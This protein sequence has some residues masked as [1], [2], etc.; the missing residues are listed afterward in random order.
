MPHHLHIIGS[1]VLPGIMGDPILEDMP[2]YYPNGIRDNYFLDASNIV[3]IKRHQDLTKLFLTTMAKMHETQSTREGQNI[4]LLQMQWTSHFEHAMHVLQQP[5]LL[6]EYRQESEKRFQELYTAQCNAEEVVGFNTAL[7]PGDIAVCQAKRNGDIFTVKEMASKLPNTDSAVL[8]KVLQHDAKNAKIVFEILTPYTWLPT[9]RPTGFQASLQK[10]YPFLI[11]L[12]EKKR[13]QTSFWVY[14]LFGPKMGAGHVVQV[15][16]HQQ[17]PWFNGLE[18]IILSFDFN[19]AAWLVAVTSNMG[20]ACQ[21]V[22]IMLEPCFSDAQLRYGKDLFAQVQELHNHRQVLLENNTRL[23]ELIHT[24]AH[25][26]QQAAGQKNQ[27]KE[28]GD[29]GRTINL[30]YLCA[31]VQ[32]DVVMADGIEDVEREKVDTALEMPLE[33]CHASASLPLMCDQKEPTPLTST[34]AEN[35]EAAASERQRLLAQLAELEQKNK[36]VMQ[37]RN[38]LAAKLEQ[39]VQKSKSLAEQQKREIAQ[40]DR[41]WKVSMHDEI[42][43][44]KNKVKKNF[45]LAVN[46]CLKVL[47]Y[48]ILEKED[49][50][51]LEKCS[52]TSRTKERA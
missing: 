46:D 29:N 38:E 31:N 17:A 20:C 25:G 8:V 52:S 6:K 4:K 35:D 22:Q 34:G 30:D 48:A 23:L 12:N 49:G 33:I 15:W 40:H 16:Q 41:A 43:R 21:G 5:G 37:E 11:V 2:G 14:E 47:D 1:N 18:V 39:E 51:C 42:S 27:N 36:E 9:P 45:L 3:Q 50:I 32:S 10:G 44:S 7:Q 24:A 19:R 13:K 26:K 28:E